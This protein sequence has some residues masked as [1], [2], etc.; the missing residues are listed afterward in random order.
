MESTYTELIERLRQY[1]YDFVVGKEQDFPVLFRDCMTAADAIETLSRSIKAYADANE[2]LNAYINDM[3]TPDPVAD[4]A[5]VTP[6]SRA[7]IL[8]RA[9]DCVCGHREQ[10]YGLAEDN[11]ATIARLWTAYRGVEFDPVDV[12]MM[13]ALLKIAR[14][15]G[16]NGSEDSFVDLAGYAA[17]GGEIWSKHHAE[18]ENME[19][20]ACMKGECNHVEAD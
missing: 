15:C 18:L 14:I 7:D 17:C 8:Q 16:G 5:E 10:D 12:A 20:A 2:R 13:M 3:R 1:R 19:R 4:V 11:F 6:A 9:S